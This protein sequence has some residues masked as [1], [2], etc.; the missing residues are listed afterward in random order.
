MLDLVYEPQA[1]QD[2]YLGQYRLREIR[3]D[4]N[5]HQE[6]CPAYHSE[7]GVRCARKG[8][9]CPFGYHVGIVGHP[10]GSGFNLVFWEVALGGNNDASNTTIA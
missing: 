1:D 7:Y 9:P 2:A 6:R 8:A 5:H 4:A 10:S 3:P